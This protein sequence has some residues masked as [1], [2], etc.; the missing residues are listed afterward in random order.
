MG[1][2]RASGPVVM[3]TRLLSLAMAPALNVTDVS[4]NLYVRIITTVRK[5]ILV[6]IVLLS[7]LGRHLIHLVHIF[8]MHLHRVL[9][10][11][12]TMT[13]LLL[14]LSKRQAYTLLPALL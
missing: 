8:T 5:I 14:P 2:L 1:S 11:L 7:I 4:T 10:A 12:A 9:S 13:I 6:T 3:V